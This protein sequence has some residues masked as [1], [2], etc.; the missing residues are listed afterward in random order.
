MAAADTASARA[1]A[2]ADEIA[3]ALTNRAILGLRYDAKLGRDVIK[4]L[5]AL[6]RD[7][8]GRVAAMDLAG[9]ASDALKR[10]RTLKMLQEA[11][12]MIRSTYRRIRLLN[13]RN[14]AELTEIE[15]RATRKL[16]N[17]GFAHANINIGIS[18]P[19]DATFAALAE[20]RLVMG[21]P[22]AE[23]LDRAGQGTIDKFA[24]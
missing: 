15:A 10:R 16:M 13:E 17:A 11:R 7:L 6:E 12:L 20:E 4:M 3:D 1:S 8:V 2:A 5:S 19:T 14:F 24:Q 18:L 22:L 21:R 23:W 9:V